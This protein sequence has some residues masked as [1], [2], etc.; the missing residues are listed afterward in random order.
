[1]N[2]VRNSKSSGAKRTIIMRRKIIEI[3]NGVKEKIPI[4]VS[5][6][7]I[8]LC[9]KD[10]GV[11][12]G[13]RY[14][15]KKLKNLFQPGQFAAKEIIEVKGNSEKSL[16]FRVIGPVR[17]ETQIELSKTDAILLGINPPIRESGD[18]KGTPG[19]TL[20][21]PKGRIKIKQ[22]VINNWRH[23]HCNLKEAKAFGLKD[24]ML[25]SIKVNGLCSVTFHNVKVR[26]EKKSRFCLHLD[27]DEG[28]AANI[29]TKGE[30]EIII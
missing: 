24:K 27:T 4:E 13:K 26:V 12:F 20:I 10:L 16:N 1:M 19:A 11:L 29:K 23:I 28:N 15:L 9:Q 3:S 18:I 17:E 21:G 7:H 5:A 8:H 22:G 30:G 2:P 25:V 6:R 14:K